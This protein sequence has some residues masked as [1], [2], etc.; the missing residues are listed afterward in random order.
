MHLGNFRETQS[1][2][3]ESNCEKCSFVKVLGL[4]GQLEKDSDIWI[5]FFPDETTKNLL[6]TPQENIRVVSA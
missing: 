1:N 3:E 6:N 4:Y 5:T 2:F